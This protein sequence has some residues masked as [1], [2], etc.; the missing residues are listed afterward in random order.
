MAGEPV[1]LEAADQF[2]WPILRFCNDDRFRKLHDKQA[3]PWPQ[4]SSSTVRES[5]VSHV[6]PRESGAKEAPEG[7][8]P[9]ADRWWPQGVPSQAIALRGA[10]KLRVGFVIFGFQVWWVTL[11]WGLLFK[12]NYH[13]GM[14]SIST[15]R[16]LC[17]EIAAAS[18]IAKVTRD[19]QKGCFGNNSS[20]PGSEWSLAVTFTVFLSSPK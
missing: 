5:M 15:A 1:L 7:T 16:G 3:P 20:D 10:G 9:S 4:A 11:G 14:P 17:F 19:R 18:V 6:R 12:H 13:T 2:L 8:L